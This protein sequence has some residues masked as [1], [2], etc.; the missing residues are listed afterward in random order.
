MSQKIELYE[1]KFESFSKNYELYEL[2]VMSRSTDYR[3][4]VL[5]VDTWLARV[6]NWKTVLKWFDVL[7]G[8][9]NDR[10]AF[11]GSILK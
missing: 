1:K 8:I 2:C 9:G 3:A 7:G 11:N 4:S 5:S 10:L 6:F